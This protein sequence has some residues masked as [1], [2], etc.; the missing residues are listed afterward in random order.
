MITYR[1]ATVD[2]ILAVD[3]LQQKYHVSSVSEEY[4][5]DGFVTTRFTASQFRELI[6]KENGLAVAC[7]GKK[8][9]AYA[10]SG[11]WEY[12]SQWELFAY[13][14]KDLPT[15]HFAG[16]QAN[17]ENSFQ[18]GP[19]CIEKAYRGQGIAAEIFEFSRQAFVKKYPIMLTFINAKN[20]RSFA[21]HT[22]KVGFEIIKTFDF[23]GNHYYELGYDMKKPVRF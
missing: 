8:I 18:Y 3:A 15:V 17:T 20:G 11:S 10:M 23:N 22:K 21:A 9:V 19:V 1:F 2:D 7:D 14:I 16:L 4:K 5:K 13:M 12:W 6:E